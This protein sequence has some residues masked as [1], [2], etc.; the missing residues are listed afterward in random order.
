M[1]FFDKIK[2]KFKK[3]RD[4]L[5]GKI[6]SLFKAFLKVDE[7]FLDNLEEILISSDICVETSS[8]IKNNLR[9]EIK[10]YKLSDPAEVIDS[11]KGI[12]IKILE[13]TENFSELSTNSITLK[14]FIGVNGAGKTTSLGKLGFNLKNNNHKVLFAAAD[15]FRAAAIEQLEFWANKIN[16]EII[17]LPEGSDPGAVIFKA[18]ETAQNNDYDIILCDTA[19]RL[20]NKENLM[21]EMSKINR[22]IKKNM[23]NNTKKVIIHETF[24]VIDSTMGQNALIQAQEF[25]KIL[26]ITGIII[27]KLDGTSRGGSIISIKDKLGIPI[28]YIGIGEK[29]DDLQEFNPTEFVNALFS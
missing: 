19:G 3:T 24:L 15:T 26:D 27:T 23:S 25:S 8:K 16:C 10:S 20:H 14:L 1:S 13:E 28:K 4:K 5:F 11:L 22:I 2:E 18:I 7:D 17:T 21:A 9:D 6:E 29:I 12:I